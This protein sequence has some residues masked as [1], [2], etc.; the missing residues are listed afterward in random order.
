MKKFV[1]IVTLLG[2]S[3]LAWA[4]EAA[5]SPMSGAMGQLLLFGGIFVAMYFM[6]IR[7]QSKKAKEHRE[8]L[9]GLSKGD[10]VVT[11]SGILGTIVRDANNYFVVNVGS[12]E[13][14]IQ[15]HSI[16]QMLPK[17]TLKSI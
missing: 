7:P 15:K 10:E 3:T 1:Q 17:G 12:S 13:M 6:T 16:A 4:E 14:F 8:L 2:M 9:A 11:T 5:A